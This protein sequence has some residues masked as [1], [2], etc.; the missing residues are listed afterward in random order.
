MIKLKINERNLIAN[1]SN[2]FTSNI[3]LF[4][5]LAQ[6]A[7][8]AGASKVEFTLD[9]KKRTLTIEDNGHG[10]KDFQNLFTIAESGWSKETINQENPFGMG[11][12]IAI[13]LSDSI[14][15]ESLGQKLVASKA[16]ILEGKELKLTKSSLSK[17]TKITLKGV[18]EAV[19]QARC[20]ESL[21]GFAIPVVIN[22][23]EVE[24]SHAVDTLNQRK[25]MVKVDFWFGTF[26]TMELNKFSNLSYMNFYFQGL[27]LKSNS[28]YGGGMTIHLKESEFKVRMPD[29]DCLLN[30]TEEIQRIKETINEWQIAEIRK[31]S[32]NYEWLV[33]NYQTLLV[34]KQ[35]EL[36]NAFDKVP[37]Q[38]FFV[39]DDPQANNSSNAEHHDQP[40]SMPSEK[41]LT[42]K[43][44]MS[45]KIVS[46]IDWDFS[47]WDKTNDFALFAYL[48]YTEALI[49]HDEVPATHW[50]Y[51][52]CTNRE[53]LEEAFNV[54]VNNMREPQVKLDVYPDESRIKMCDSFTLDSV[55]GMIEVKNSA[56]TVLADDQYLTLIPSEEMSGGIVTQ[57]N[58]FNGEYSYDESL[59]SDYF[60][61]MTAWLLQERSAG[62]PDQVL[63]IAL[64]RLAK[65]VPTL[66]GKTFE[67]YFN[68]EGDVRVRFI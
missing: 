60:D 10:I 59:E 26:Y 17:G 24:R 5:E 49:I 19:F 65:D 36:F 12:L 64:E 50:I 63:S 39:I 6:N 20:K 55:F 27:P 11:F 38:F 35:L 40:M 3:N 14:E 66:K 53:T 4:T 46:P 30:E 18:E 1:L 45:K 16:E 15:V 58:S 23:K 33:D 9:E 7:R 8:R 61:R 37:A 2:A 42:K 28:S 29:R 48:Y 54:S 43:E 62:N 52:M 41:V 21:K 67:V 32:K 22:G 68:E 51:E 57:M 31:N 56:L 25:E 13:Y 47:Q 34:H 44:L